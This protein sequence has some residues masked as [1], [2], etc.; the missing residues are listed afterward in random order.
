MGKAFEGVNLAQS[1]ADRETLQTSG[2][3]GQGLAG[4]EAWSGPG[5][6][7]VV[8]YCALNNVDSA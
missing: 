3:Y 1:C 5:A 2:L 8:A 7:G 4:L 6:W